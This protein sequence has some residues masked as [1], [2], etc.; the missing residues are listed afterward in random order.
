MEDESR[1]TRWLP[2]R[3]GLCSSGQSTDRWWANQSRTGP[4]DNSYSAAPARRTWQTNLSLHYLSKF[5]QNRELKRP[6]QLGSWLYSRNI[7]LTV[8][9]NILTLS[10]GVAGK[11]PWPR[12]QIHPGQSPSFIGVK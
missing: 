12:P 11:T 7:S 2:D 5:F 6:A 3:P 4:W 9:T 1:A 8:S 10:S